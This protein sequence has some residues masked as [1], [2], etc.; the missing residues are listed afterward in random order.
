MGESLGGDAPATRTTDNIETIPDV[1]QNIQI[2][3]RQITNSYRIKSVPK[4]SQEVVL[5]QIQVNNEKTSGL[6]FIRLQYTVS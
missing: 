2:S 1:F 3:I 4:F 6:L 5:K